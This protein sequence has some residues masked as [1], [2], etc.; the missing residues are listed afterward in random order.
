MK[1][2]YNLIYKPECYHGRNQRSNFFEGWYFKVVDKF[3]RYVFAIIPGIFKSKSSGRSHSF[4]QIINAIQD[5]SHYLKFDLN[6]FNAREDIFE[7]EIGENFF[8]LNQIKLNIDR[9]S[10]KIEAEI[11]F[12][13]LKPWPVTKTSPG[14]MGWYS[15]IPIMECYHGVLSLDHKVKG[16]IK[17]QDKRI[18]LDGGKGYMEKDWGSNF[19]SSYVWLQSNHF[20]EEGISLSG[21]I[22]KVP[23]LGTHFRG[24]IFGFLFAG[25]LYKFTTYA[26]GKL[27]YLN[28][29]ES[30]IE[31]KLRNKEYSLSVNAERTSNGKKLYAPYEN[32]MI[33][34][35]VENL[36]GIVIVRLSDLQDNIIFEGKGIH[37][38][39]EANGNLEEIADRVG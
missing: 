24:F 13:E 28:V 32:D 29:S 37:S 2:H 9:E 17:N 10:L 7:V 22:A 31:I 27:D 15:Y 39:V 26:S 36:D 12:D 16:F 8:S 11:N 34:R 23:W 38:G 6:E 5:K 21:S 3:G 14:V 4:I 33:E 1:D 18:E 19:P 20:E 25:Q 35:V 30:L